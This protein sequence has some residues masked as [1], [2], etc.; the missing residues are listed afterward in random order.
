M[1]DKANITEE[2]KNV[3][4]SEP[5]EKPVRE[6][7]E[8]STTRGTFVLTE[9]KR[10]AF[11]GLPFTFTRYTLKEDVLTIDSGFFKKVQ[12]DCYMYKIQDVRLERG[13]FQRWFGLGDVICY[14]GDSTHQQLILKNIRHSQD[15]K[16]FI[17]K[18]SE[19]ARLKRRTINTLNIDA[20]IDG[21]V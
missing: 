12:N 9:R 4:V 6:D 16:D 13:F 20:A 7:R 21:D 3:T 5:D 15:A 17:L 19:E 1:E 8:P 11:L 2:M 14:T 10:W 18:F